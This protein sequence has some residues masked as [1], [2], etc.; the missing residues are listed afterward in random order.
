MTRSLK[1]FPEGIENSMRS[2]CR[3][4]RE[5]VRRLIEGT[6]CLVGEEKICVWDLFHKTR[7]ALLDHIE[8]EMKWAL[9]ALEPSEREKHRAEHQALLGKLEEARYEFETSAGDRFRRKF[10]EFAALLK[11]HH[12]RPMY[13]ASAGGIRE[14][15]IRGDRNWRRIRD[16]VEHGTVG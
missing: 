10:E 16:R 3:L 14:E 15:E 2:D 11:E 13:V 5:A 9:P 7:E 1:I 8:F 4:I 6:C 12:A